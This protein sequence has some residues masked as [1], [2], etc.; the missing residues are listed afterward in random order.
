MTDLSTITEYAIRM[1][2]EEISAAYNA[3]NNAGNGYAVGEDGDDNETALGTSYVGDAGDLAVGVYMGNVI[4]VS[5]D[6][7]GS[8]AVDVTAVF[9][10]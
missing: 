10:A 7:L 9:A 3:G 4:A 6:L 2:A 5:G 8:W 1:H